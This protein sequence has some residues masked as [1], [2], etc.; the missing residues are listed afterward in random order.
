MHYHKTPQAVV[1]L[2]RRHIPKSACK[3]LEPAVGE[4]ALLEALYPSQLHKELTLVDIDH[5]RLDAI[6]AI[7]PELSLINADFI[8]WSESRNAPTF[9]LIITNPPFSGRSENWIWFGGQK[10][11]IEYAFFR[12]CVELLEKNGTLVAIVP[13]TLVNSSR[14]S[15][16][17]A[18]IFSQGAITYSYQLPERIFDKIEGA[19]YLL[20]FKKGVRQQYVKLRSLTGQPEIKVNKAILT[21]TDYRLDHSFYKSF[22]NLNSFIPKNPLRLGEICT[23]GRGPIR[24]NYKLVGNHHSNS[25]SEGFWRS[26]TSQKDSNLCI[27]VKRVSRNAHLS[28]G[29]FQIQDIEKSTDCIVFIKAQDNELSKILFY[30]RV[31]MTNEDGKS[32]L[33]KGSGAKFIQVNDLKSMPY[34]DIAKLFPAEYE[35]FTKAYNSFDINLCLD[36]ERTVYS[37][38]VW[39]DSVIALRSSKNKTFK[40]DELLLKAI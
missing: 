2:A 17:R 21:S 22:K 13:D 23:V 32:L 28:F 4:G 11:P 5:R 39:G 19:F 8:G 18:W 30:L 12:R 3:V 40:D 20:V 27:A 15:T 26:F 29:F 16:E 6:K 35:N 10:A 33:L 9:D 25:F 24:S 31:V 1:R 37:K 34:M 14:L 38:L 7:Y 36:I